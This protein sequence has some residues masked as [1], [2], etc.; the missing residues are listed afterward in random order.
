MKA[1]PSTNQ[2]GVVKAPSVTT[3]ST[4]TVGTPRESVTPEAPTD[5]GQSQKQPAIPKRANK[6]GSET[7]REEA[8]KRSTAEVLAIL[9][10][11]LC[12]GWKPFPD[13]ERHVDNAFGDAIV[14]ARNARE[15]LGRHLFGRKT[16]VLGYYIDDDVVGSDGAILTRDGEGGLDIGP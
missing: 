15:L 9:T 11:N 8:W 1:K 12:E 10:Q 2:D 14:A 6:T 4:K 13:L 3:D 7:K 16:T 5:A